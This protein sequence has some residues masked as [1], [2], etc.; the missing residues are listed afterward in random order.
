[1][2]YIRQYVNLLSEWTEIKENIHGNST[3]QYR[4]DIVNKVFDL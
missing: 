3:P 2:T 1:M 4:N